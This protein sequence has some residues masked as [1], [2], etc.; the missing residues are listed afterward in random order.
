MQKQ[1]IYDLS[2]RLEFWNIF[3]EFLGEDLEV[4]SNL[5]MSDVALFYISDLVNKFNYQYLA[6]C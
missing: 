4:L 3:Q 5:I 1:L 6:K 2:L